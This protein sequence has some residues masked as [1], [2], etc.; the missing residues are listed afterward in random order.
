[1]YCIVHHYYLSIDSVVMVG[2]GMTD[3]ETCPP[4]VSSFINSIYTFLIIILQDTFI[5]FGGNVERLSVKE[6][7]PWY[8]YNMRELIDVLETQSDD[9]NI[10]PLTQP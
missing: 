6:V 8:I 7:A 3:Y 4:A 9:D 2:D 1:M 5:G 10:P